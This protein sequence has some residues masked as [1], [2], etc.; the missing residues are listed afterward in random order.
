M[1]KERDNRPYCLNCARHV[2]YKI[3]RVLEDSYYVLEAV[4]C[5]CGEE[6]Y[7]PLINDINV[8]TR[9][10]AREFAA[11]AITEEEECF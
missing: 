11:T 4:C 8:D 1:T 9:L 2:G 10:R 3:R 7:S 5:R 6:V